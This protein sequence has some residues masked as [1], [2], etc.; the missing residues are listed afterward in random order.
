MTPAWQRRAGWCS[1]CSEPARPFSDSRN[2]PNSSEPPELCLRYVYDGPVIGVQR[3]ERR[4]PRFRHPSLSLVRANEDPV[5]DEIPNHP[6]RSAN[7]RGRHPV[8]V[9]PRLHTTGPGHAPPR[10]STHATPRKN[11]WR[12][13]IADRQVRKWRLPTPPGPEVTAGRGD[14]RGDLCAEAAGPRT[15]RGA[16]CQASCSRRARARFSS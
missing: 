16:E 1:A 8:D 7:R 2:T 5:P 15:A 12:H 9:L 3:V 4:Q 10:P 6:V 11:P 14:Q 13:G